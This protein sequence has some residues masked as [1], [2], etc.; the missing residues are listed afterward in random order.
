MLAVFPPIRTGVQTVPLPNSH[1]TVSY[2]GQNK[3]PPFI[4]RP[5]SIEAVVRRCSVKKVLLKISQKLRKTPVPESLF[6]K[7]A[8]L[9]LY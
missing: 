2:S 4:K 5:L 9:Q 6:N 3:A 7:V 1:Y 8:G